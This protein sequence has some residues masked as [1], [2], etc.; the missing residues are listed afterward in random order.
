MRFIYI[1]KK[2]WKWPLLGRP[3]HK[4]EDNIKINIDEIY[5]QKDVYL[6]DASGSL[7]RWVL[8]FGIV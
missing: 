4:C 7:G 5:G 3:N 2:P 1:I 6:L 8:I